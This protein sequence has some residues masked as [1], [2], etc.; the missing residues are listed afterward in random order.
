MSTNVKEG[1]L[2]M[3]YPDGYSG[4][5]ACELVDGSLTDIPEQTLPTVVRIAG[6]IELTQK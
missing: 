1:S 5:Q 2:P 3:D 4:D 6:L